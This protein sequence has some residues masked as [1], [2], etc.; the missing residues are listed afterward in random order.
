MNDRTRN[1]AVEKSN[2]CD[3]LNTDRY[4]W[5][6]KAVDWQGAGWYRLEQPAGVV[7]P[8]ISPGIVPNNFSV[9]QY[10]NSSATNS[11][12]CLKITIIV[13]KIVLTHIILHKH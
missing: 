7:I 12:Y 4:H 2:R 10:L 9:L 13:F 6:R 8:E 5:A 1:V 3:K 11:N